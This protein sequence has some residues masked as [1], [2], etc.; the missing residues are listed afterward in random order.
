M[1]IK[2]EIINQLSDNYSYII[3][4]IATKEALVVDPSESNPIINFINNNHL[5]LSFHLEDK[6]SL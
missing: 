5:L 3:Y 1:N 2:V 4:S 6:A